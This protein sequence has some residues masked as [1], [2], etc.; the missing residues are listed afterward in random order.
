[1]TH[2]SRGLIRRALGVTLVAL[3]LPSVG[4]ANAAEGGTDRP[5]RIWAT[6][7][8]HTTGTVSSAERC[9]SVPGKI[10]LFETY[11]IGTGH[12]THVGA[13]SFRGDHCTYF[14]T[15]TNGTWYGFGDW[16]LTAA[17][18]DSIAAPY[19]MS[20]TPAPEDPTVD[21]VTVA[22]HEIAG[23]TGRFEDASGWMDCT[24]KLRITDPATFTADMWG[25]CR[26]Q[27]SY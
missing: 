12:A 10:L 1:M 24:L 14:D 15:A 20:L 13:Y 23:G 2:A 3:L 8:L 7:A 22:S 4:A 19:Q 18:R 9:P 16:V 5:M 17:N 27:I 6:N 25:S 26:G 21:I 11:V